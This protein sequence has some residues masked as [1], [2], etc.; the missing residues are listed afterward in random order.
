MDSEDCLNT[1]VSLDP[2]VFFL[3]KEWNHGCVV[4]MN[5][6]NIWNK[7][8]FSI[9]SRAQPF[10]RNQNAHHHPTHRIPYHG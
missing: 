10:G 4:V 6:K 1:L 9:N 2:M 7:V 8:H 5:M 3:E